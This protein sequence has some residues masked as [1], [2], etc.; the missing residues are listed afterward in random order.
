MK[1]ILLICSSSLSA[2]AFVLKMMKSAKL[3][4]YDVNIWSVGSGN[5]DESIDRADIILLGPQV[6]YLFDD[7]KKRVDGKKP[8]LLIGLEDY[9]SMNS[10]KI[11]QECLLY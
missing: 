3:M 8:I 1:N 7:V 10:K 2:N 5:F 9:S 6:K 4:N 11:L